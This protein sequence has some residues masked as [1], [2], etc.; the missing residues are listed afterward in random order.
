MV[1][2]GIVFFGSVGFFCL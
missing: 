2:S 1:L